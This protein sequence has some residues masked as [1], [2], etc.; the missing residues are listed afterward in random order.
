M[1]RPPVR[2]DGKPD[3]RITVIP[4]FRK[5]AIPIV[6]LAGITLAGCATPPKPPE[7]SYD[8]NVPPLPAAPASVTD[9]RPKPLH[10]PPAWTPAAGTSSAGRQFR[11]SSQPV[12]GPRF[13]RQAIQSA[14]SP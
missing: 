4:I 14:S 6:L 1:S 8:R 3:F 7:I 2:K 12:I 10:V 5:S 11:C 9:N 13:F